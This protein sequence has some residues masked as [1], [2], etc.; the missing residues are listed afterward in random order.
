MQYT[1]L[2][3]KP[4]YVGPE[5]PLRFLKVALTH[6]LISCF[7]AQEKDDTDG[8]MV[9][10]CRSL[11]KAICSGYDGNLPLK[12]TITFM[13]AR[14]PPFNCLNPLSKAV[15]RVLTVPW[16]DRVDEAFGRKLA[17]NKGLVIECGKVGLRARSFPV[18]VGFR[19]FAAWCLS[20]KPS[21]YGGEGAERSHQ[22]HRWSGSFK[23]ALAQERSTM[24][25]RAGHLDTNSDL[26]SFGRV[27]WWRLYNVE[28][29]DDS[30]S[31]SDD[32]PRSK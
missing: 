16:E 1:F 23:M 8:D 6:I 12:H 29:P 15:L 22:Q 24:E 2:L 18:Q 4:S 9:K 11:L 14:E 20:D 19:G 3:V 10:S 17:K 31:I 26:I 5:S 28:R 30:R 27:T 25:D 21:S 32:V 13:R 7:T